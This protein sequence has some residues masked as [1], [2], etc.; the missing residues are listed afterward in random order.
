LFVRLAT[1]NQQSFRLIFVAYSLSL[2]GCGH[3]SDR[4]LEET[5]EQSYKIEP[6]TSISIKNVDGSIQVYGS[7]AHE[8]T[9]QATK[10]AYSTKR[11]KQ[12]AV[13]V[14]V[15]PGTVAIETTSPREPTWGL[16][17]RSGTVDYTIV[18]PDTASISRLELANGEVSVEEMRGQSVHA[19]LE[20][21]Q[22]FTHNCF[23]NVDVTIGR[24]T[25]IVAYEWWEP[26]K[27]SVQTNIADGNAW[28]FLP[29]DAAFHLIAE[30]VHGRIASDFTAVGEHSAQA[31]TKVDVLV[32]GGGETEIR[33][34]AAEG[35]I[36]VV[37][38][39]P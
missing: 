28:A 11:L 32:N 36:K 35:N 26:G 34:R 23:S 37:E 1:F 10:R 20:T 25:L 15:Q 9:L 30:A 31:M 38:Q 21:G 2:I 6:T 29:S 12:I 5:V 24:G 3:A 33:M 16:L 8:M 18:V 27:F 14:S 7:P 19:R 13:D 4:V 22:L 17:D 39:N